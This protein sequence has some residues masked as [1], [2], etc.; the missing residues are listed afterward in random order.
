MSMDFMDMFSSLSSASK[1]DAYFERLEKALK[2]KKLALEVSESGIDEEMKQVIVELIKVTR[3][4][5]KEVIEEH[6]TKKS[7]PTQS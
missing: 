7:N 2:I 5:L 1:V 4:E 6:E 3:L